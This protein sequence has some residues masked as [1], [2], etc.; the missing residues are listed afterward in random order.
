MILF[1]TFILY[2]TIVGK[3]IINYFSNIYNNEHIIIL[4]IRKL[5]I[6]DQTNDILTFFFTVMLKD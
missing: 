3:K 1:I 6:I 2:E 4:P 5:V